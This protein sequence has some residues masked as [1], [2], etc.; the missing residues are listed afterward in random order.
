MLERDLFM[1]G[2]SELVAAHPGLDAE[3]VDTDTHEDDGKHGA[4]DGGAHM[5]VAQLQL[6]AKEGAVHEGAQNIG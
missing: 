2:P 3:E 5:R 6:E 1:T 4:S